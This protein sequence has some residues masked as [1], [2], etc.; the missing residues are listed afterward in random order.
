M[1]GDD[2]NFPGGHFGIHGSFRP[3]PDG[4]GYRNAIFTA[5]VIGPVVQFLIHLRIKNQLA[6][7]GTVAQIDKNHPAVI[8]P[9]PNPAA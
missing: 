1:I 9:V 6:M 3:H 8:A 4:S 7:T 2:F 5:Q